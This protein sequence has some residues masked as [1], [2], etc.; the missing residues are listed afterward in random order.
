MKNTDK[1][2]E[3]IFSDLN[4]LKS[5]LSILDNNKCLLENNPIFASQFQLDLFKKYYKDCF[6]EK[7]YEELE[8]MIVNKMIDE[9][10]SIFS[11]YEFE[12]N[13]RNLL[14]LTDLSN[15]NI[16]SISVYE[17]GQQ[18]E[19]VKINPLLKEIHN[20]FE[21]LSRNNESVISKLEDEISEVE[22]EMAKY[23]IYMK[24]PYTYAAETNQLREFIVKK[25]KIVNKIKVELN[26][27]T[28]TY[29]SLKQE[30]MYQNGIY[31][32]IKRKDEFL[33]KDLDSIY[34]SLVRKFNFKKK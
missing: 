23:E 6:K 15:E 30:L 27:L 2:F 16:I 8:L 25:N 24:K 10:K 12:F 17:D 3:K 13:I 34:D 22:T 5:N 21:H 29:Y 31:E 26:D 32:D 20:S 33:K 1:V 9:L 7:E 4:I 18:V 19:L 11:E 28:R 14:S